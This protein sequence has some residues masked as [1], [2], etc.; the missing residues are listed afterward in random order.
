MLILIFKVA[1]RTTLNIKYMKSFDISYSSF[2]SSI[3]RFLH[4][5][6]GKTYLLDWSSIK[7]I[8][9]C[10][11]RLMLNLVWIRFSKIRR[12]ISEIQLIVWKTRKRFDIS[13]VCIFIL[14]RCKYFV[15]MKGEGITNKCSK[16]TIFSIGRYSMSFT[17]P[18]KLGLRVE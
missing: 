9:Q 5:S 17:H 2:N 13:P 15:E 3:I 18:A 12:A 8:G 16:I 7:F 14:Y 1:S 10:H 6:N 4:A 11:W